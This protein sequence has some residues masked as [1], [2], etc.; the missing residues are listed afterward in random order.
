[1]NGNKVVYN[2]RNV[3]E[4][5]YSESLQQPETFLFIK[6]GSEISGKSVLDIG[7]GAGRTSFFLHRVSAGYV[8]CDFAESMIDVCRTRFPTT[9]F[10]VVDARE[11]SLFDDNSF[12]TVI[13]S[14]NGLDCIN[15]EGRIQALSEIRRVLR[16][17]GLFIFSFHNRAYSGFVGRPPL[18]FCLNPIRMAR[19][20]AGW[21]LIDLPNH[22]KSRQLAVVHDD[23]ELR[24]DSSHRWQM[25]HYYIN[26]RSQE[27]QLGRFGFTVLDFVDWNGRCLTADSD[28]SH[29]GTIYV[30]SRCSKDQ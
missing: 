16:H 14:F 30:A 11:M 15:H 13:F 12:D 8:G 24:N 28:D 20:M 25:V 3:A 2:R 26:R 6:Y 9:R 1:M 4:S 18:N 29:S 19:R 5:W 21:W 7:V 10:E 22:R 27:V 23:Y 17:N